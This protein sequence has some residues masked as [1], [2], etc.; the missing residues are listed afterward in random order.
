MYVEEIE[1]S[2][3][4]PHMDFLRRFRKLDECRLAVIGS[5]GVRSARDVFLESVTSILLSDGGNLSLALKEMRQAEGIK[6]VEISFKS[7]TLCGVTYE[8]R[9]S[10]PRRMFPRCGHIVYPVIITPEYERWIVVFPD[11]ERREQFYSV[12]DENA[13]LYTRKSLDHKI[14]VELLENLGLV[15]ATLSVR[16]ELTE[17]QRK[18]LKMAY[19]DGFFEI[20]KRTSV[21]NLAEKVGISESAVI[22]TIKRG[23]KKILSKILKYM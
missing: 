12:V 21:R 18:L 20:P 7:K 23:E 3:S 15:E 9:A 17:K 6:N 10:E 8:L 2:H 11:K 13:E 16:N 1:F 22:R 5:Y 14:L 19:R 4:C